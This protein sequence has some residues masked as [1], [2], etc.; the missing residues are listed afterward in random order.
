MWTSQQYGHKSWG[1]SNLLL[2]SLAASYRE[3]RLSPG[4]SPLTPTH[5]QGGLFPVNKLFY[6]RFLLQC[7]KIDQKYLGIFKGNSL[8]VKRAYVAADLPGKS[9]VLSE[10]CAHAKMTKST[11]IYLV[12]LL[13]PSVQKSPI[14]HVFKSIKYN[15]VHKHSV[16]ITIM[17]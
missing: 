13:P 8:S 7:E 6:Q 10:R 5:E 2:F 15:Y 11:E 3:I 12:S 1:K 17:E 14:V 9:S 16:W 4:L